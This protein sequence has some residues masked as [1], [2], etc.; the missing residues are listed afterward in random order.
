MDQ[1]VYFLNTT[2]ACKRDRFVRILHEDIFARPI[3]AQLHA[4][5]FS[6]IGLEG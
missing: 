5:L 2:N 3:L 1:L 4:D 6:K